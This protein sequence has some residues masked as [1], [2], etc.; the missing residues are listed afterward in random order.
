MPV[1]P[2]SP[3][4]RRRLLRVLVVAIIGAGIAVA[5]LVIPNHSGRT[6]QHFHAGKPYVVKV[7]K[8]IPV[9]A[10]DRAAIDRLLDR[11]VADAVARRD[12]GAAYGLATASLRAGTTRADWK[13]GSLPVQPLQV[14]GST[15]HGWSPS[16]SYRNEV[17]FD[18]L[19]HAKPGS[20][21]GAIS[22]T[23]DVKRVG[24]RWLVD[25]F[26]PTALFAAQGETS[27]ITAGVDYGPSGALG[28]PAK[29]GEKSSGWL[30]VPLLFLVLPGI[31]LAAMLL[32]AW[33]THRRDERIYRAAST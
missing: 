4:V 25:S 26:V 20:K 33:R 14:R 9:G 10:R 28:A 12:P 5:A 6:A 19:V 13:G 11:F 27:R 24:D 1:V 3:R 31:G 21:I 22:Y 23:V 18:L 17:N 7:Q 8:Q 15:F 29:T 30:S 32:I 2:T 16:Y